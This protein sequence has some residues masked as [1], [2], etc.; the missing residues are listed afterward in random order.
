MT[1]ELTSADVVQLISW[2]IRGCWTL[3]LKLEHDHTRIMTGRKKILGTMRGKDPKAIS[4]PTEGLYAHTLGHIP[5][6][7]A[8]ILRVGNDEFLLGVEETARYI[9]GMAAEG[10]YL[11]SL[12]LAHSPEFDLTIICRTCQ[13]GQGGVKGCPIHATVMSLQDVFDH[14]IIGTKKL[15]LDIQGSCRSGRGTPIAIG[16]R[17]AGKS[18]LH[19]CRSP[20]LLL[21]K[22]GRV[23]HTHSLVQTGTDNKIL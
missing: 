21:A 2:S 5:D 12:G 14:N 7:N 4:L 23:P 1:E 16:V 9:V 22:P 15:C 10:I 17:H 6:T 13:Q 3:P 20:Q 19:S 11:P 18:P 8:A